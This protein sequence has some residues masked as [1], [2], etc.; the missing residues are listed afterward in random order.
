AAICLA[1]KMS[2]ELEAQGWP[3]GIIVDSGNGA[4]ILYR[5]DLPNDEPS[6]RLTE[7]VLKALA[8]HY[9]NAALGLDDK[10]FNASR[11]WKLP[12]TLA[13]KGDATAERPH[14][15]ARRLSS[16]SIQTVTTEQLMAIAISVEKPPAK[17]GCR[18]NHRSN[19]DLDA[20]LGSYGDRYEKSTWK[21]G[22]KYVFETCPNDPTHK[23]TFCVTQQPNGGGISAKCQHRSCEGFNWP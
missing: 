7:R 21:G 14:R 13:M 4:Q 5:I 11:V 20:L 19:F 10:V 12:G 22:T 3:A 2:G 16:A 1:H 15:L 8:Q 6:A 9:N 17:R 23:R 18:N